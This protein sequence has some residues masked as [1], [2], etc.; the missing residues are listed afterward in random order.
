VTMPHSKRPRRNK[1]N[2]IRKRQGLPPLPAHIAVT[3]V[4]VR[5]MQ[6][7]GVTTIMVPLPTPVRELLTIARHAAQH[8]DPSI[9]ASD[10]LFAGALLTAILTTMLEQAAPSMIS[11]PTSAE[12]QKVANG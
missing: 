6:P 10:Q 5:Y 1:L 9:K 11:A 4:D 2:K 7:V 3:D 12:I 8:K